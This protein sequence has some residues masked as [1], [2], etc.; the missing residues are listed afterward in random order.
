MTA[1]WR[2]FETLAGYAVPNTAR[3]TNYYVVAMGI[4]DD[5]ARV[6]ATNGH[7]CVP[8]C[9]RLVVKV[10]HAEQR[11]LRKL[12]MGSTVYVARLRKDGSFGNAKP[13]STCRR[14]LRS[15]RVTR[16]FYTLSDTEYG[17]IE[18]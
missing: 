5:G 15:K 13:C 1:V 18:F 12:D 7:V 2:N 17:C 16:A 6:F 3:E 14:M 9:E 4:R 10:A 8:K 11:L